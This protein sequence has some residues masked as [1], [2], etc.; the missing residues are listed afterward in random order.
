MKKVFLLGAL[1]VGSISFANFNNLEEFNEQSNTVI[2]ED[3][4]CIVWR[5]EKTIEPQLEYEI[6]S[7]VR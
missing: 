6:C 1:I 3:A 2:V 5:C 7:C 4:G